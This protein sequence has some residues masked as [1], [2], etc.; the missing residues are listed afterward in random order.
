MKFSLIPLTKSAS[1]LLISPVYMVHTS[2]IIYHMA[3][4]LH[5]Y[6]FVYFILAYHVI[7]QPSYGIRLYA[8]SSNIYNIISSIMSTFYVSGHI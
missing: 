1:F 4:L 5:I 3:L 7:L 2:I 6:H 8:I